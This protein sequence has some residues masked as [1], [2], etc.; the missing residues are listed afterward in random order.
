MVEISFVAATGCSFQRCAPI[1]PFILDGEARCG[2]QRTAAILIAGFA[3][4]AMRRAVFSD[5]YN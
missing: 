1:A 3:P 5:Y 4:A 2:M